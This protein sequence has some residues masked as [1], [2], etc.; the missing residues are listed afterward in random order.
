MTVSDLFMNYLKSIRIHF[1]GN[2]TNAAVRC[3]TYRHLAVQT[4]L[5]VQLTVDT[6]NKAY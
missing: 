3:M 1:T 2:N 4:N 5:P 6:D